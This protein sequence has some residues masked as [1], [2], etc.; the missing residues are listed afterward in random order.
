MLVLGELRHHVLR[1][2]GGADAGVMTGGQEALP[3]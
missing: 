1:G 2:G 3:A